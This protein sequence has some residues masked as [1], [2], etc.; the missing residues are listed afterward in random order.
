LGELIIFVNIKKTVMKKHKNFGRKTVHHLVPRIRIRDYYG[1]GVSLP[2]NKLKIWEYKHICWHFLFK[3]KTINE[4]IAYLKKRN[5]PEYYKSSA[6]IT[7]FK[8]KTPKQA[9]NLLIRVRR[10]IRKKHQFFELDPMLKNKVKKY[11]K[12]LGAIYVDINLQRKF[13]SA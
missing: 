10:A 8:N 5:E 9:R 4:V 11:H 7:L 6:W 2:S 13:K 1:A 3:L 12:K